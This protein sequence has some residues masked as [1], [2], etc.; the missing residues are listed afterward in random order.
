[1]TIYNVVSTLNYNVYND[2]VS[3]TLPNAGTYD[4]DMALPVFCVPGNTADCAL[5]Y[6]ISTNSTTPDSVASNIIGYY[7]MCAGMQDCLVT[8]TFRRIMYVSSA[9]TIYLIVWFSGGTK[10]Y[11]TVYA[12]A[13]I[14]YTRIA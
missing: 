6:C 12:S 8:P 11:A 3:I 9:T 1:M 14:R 5:K 2:I 4:C 10:T 13:F 7:T